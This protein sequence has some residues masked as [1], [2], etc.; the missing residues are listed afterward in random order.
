MARGRAGQIYLD[1]RLLGTAPFVERRIPIGE[2]T[3][4]VVRAGRERMFTIDVRAGSVHTIDPSGQLVEPQ[5]S[6]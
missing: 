1:G 2:H 4:R 6:D 3:V 5:P